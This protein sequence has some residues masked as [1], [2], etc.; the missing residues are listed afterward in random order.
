MNFPQSIAVPFFAIVASLSA[1][2]FPAAATAAPSTV[3]KPAAQPDAQVPGA[4]KG[5]QQLDVAESDGARL[6]SI[7]KRI[8]ILE[9]EKRI[10]EL[11]KAIRDANASSG[12]TAIPAGMPAPVGG[13]PSFNRV[14]VS[15]PMD[16]DSGFV[17]VKGI[18][19]YNGTFC[20]TLAA[21]GRVDDVHVGDTFAGWRVMKIT[22][23]DVT[24]TRRR[25]GKAETRV[26]RL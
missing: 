3:A 5:G 13:P 8:P 23:A 16:L 19:S 6:A 18:D 9:A 26:V 4:I 24:L 20:A 11:E 15:P 21:A 17:E 12:L 14:P 2:A 1:H 10:A 25:A 7:Q 22:A